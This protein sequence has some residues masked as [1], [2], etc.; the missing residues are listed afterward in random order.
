MGRFLGVTLEKISRCLERIE[1]MRFKD[2]CP[3]YPPLFIIGPP[4]TGTTLLYQLMVHG[5]ELSYFSNLANMFHMSSCILS[6]LGKRALREHPSDFQSDFGYAKG[7]MAPHEGGKIWNR[8]FPRAGREGFHYAGEGYLSPKAKSEIRRVLAGIERIFGAPFINKNVKNS[9]RIRALG[10]IFSDAIFL[11]VKRDPLQVVSS[12]LAARRK[13]CKSIND[14][15]SVMPKEIGL[16]RD[17]HY[18]EQVCG[19]F[20]YIEKDIEEDIHHIGED[21]RFV[22]HYEDIC[23][24]PKRVMESIQSFLQT[25]GISLMTKRSVPDSFPLSKG[26]TGLESFERE[27]LNRVLSQLYG[28][29]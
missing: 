1:L 11:H 20:Y 19:Q 21:Q 18:L 29:R 2:P 10:E 5:F 28:E 17:K 22:L 23:Q 6:E 27:G 9:V 14:W 7:L 15:W 3:N 8:W 12:I 25:K 13:N 24:S 4:R 26:D 16:I